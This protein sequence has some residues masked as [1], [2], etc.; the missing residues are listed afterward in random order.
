MTRTLI[1]SALVVQVGV[2]MLAAQPGTPAESQAGAF[3]SA[4][5]QAISRGDRAAV[6]EMVRYPLVA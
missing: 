5:A 1:A 3:V 2:A 6:A 4:L